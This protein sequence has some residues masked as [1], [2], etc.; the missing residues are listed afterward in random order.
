MLRECVEAYLESK[1][2]LAS[3]TRHR[4]RRVLCALT[5]YRISGAVPL[6]DSR[7]AKVTTEQ[8]RRFHKSPDADIGMRTAKEYLTVLKAFFRD[9]HADKLIG[10]D[11]A[12]GLRETRKPETSVRAIPK[13]AGAKCNCH[14]PKRTSQRH[15]GRGGGLSNVSGRGGTGKCR[16]GQPFGQ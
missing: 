2:Q 12:L 16:G 14:D 7:I 4:Y 6:G 11:P 10:E 15:K 13:R 8:L 1:S 5:D 3:K 9:T